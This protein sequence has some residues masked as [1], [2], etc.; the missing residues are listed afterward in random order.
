MRVTIEA[1]L[2]HACRVETARY[3][4]FI[5]GLLNCDMRNVS[6]I[7]SQDRSVSEI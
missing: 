7:T 5:Y 6:C 1:S 2:A 4:I 3:W